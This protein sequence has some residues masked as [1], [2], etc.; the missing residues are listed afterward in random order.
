MK[1]GTHGLRVWQQAD[2]RLQENTMKVKQANYPQK[3]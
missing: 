2:K 1:C 3:M